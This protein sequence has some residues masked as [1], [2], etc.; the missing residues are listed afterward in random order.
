MSFWVGAAAVILGYLFGAVSFTRILGRWVL[1]GD[2]LS[3]VEV[4]LGEGTLRFNRTSASLISMKRG[5]AYGC[6]TGLLDMA[7]AAIPVLIF[8]VAFPDYDDEFFAAAAAVVGH[9][10]PVYY[11][12]HGGAGLSPYLGGLA[13][14]DLL[15]VPVVTVLGT[16]TGALLRNVVI[17]YASGV[18]WLIP[19]FWWRDASWP[20]FAYAFIVNVA[21]WVALW[22]V[23]TDLTRMQRSGEIDRKEAMRILR[24]GHPSLDRDRYQSD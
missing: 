6:L 23:M 2:D 16:L 11:K 10:F 14:L 18:I 1:P 13:V 7:K 8:K 19:W 20:A 24:S 9:N 21:V 12:F 22:P 15:A 3:G 17:A 5:P 4:K